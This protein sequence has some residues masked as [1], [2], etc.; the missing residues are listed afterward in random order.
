LK[1]I[2]VPLPA[3]SG[4]T[5]S[6]KAEKMFARPSYPMSVKGRIEPVA[7]EDDAVQKGEKGKGWW[8][9]TGR[10][11]DGLGAADRDVGKEGRL[12]ELSRSVSML[13]GRRR[14]AGSLGKSKKAR[15]KRTKF[16][17]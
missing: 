8:E 15:I 14:H 5:A 2:I 9:G 13:R 10:T 4:E 16:V 17:P 7:V 11:D 3:A 6:V 12:L 1:A